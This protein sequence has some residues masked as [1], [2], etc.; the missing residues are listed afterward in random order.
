LERGDVVRVL[1]RRVATGMSE[2]VQAYR[3]DLTSDAEGLAEFADG[4]VVLYHCA[5]ETRDT[6]KMVEVNVEG[7][8]RLVEAASNRIGHWVQLSSIAVYGAPQYGVITEET[9][10][11][12]ATAYG[13]SKA[14]ADRLVIEAGKRGE[15]ACSILRPAKIF[16]DG[17]AGGNNQI[18]RRMISIIDSGLFFFVGIRGPSLTTF[19]STTSWRP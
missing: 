3:G 17:M 8:R 12:P 9:P 10:S 6:S 14:E 2:E 16:G 19:T 7:T 13:A 11:R 1:S 18:L 4:A 5:A 15:I